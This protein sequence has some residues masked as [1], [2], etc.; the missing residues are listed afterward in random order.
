[1]SERKA[2]HHQPRQTPPNPIQTQPYLH[3]LRQPALATHLALAHNEAQRPLR[4]LHAFE[5]VRAVLV[6][7]PRLCPDRRRKVEAVAA[8]VKVLAH[9]AFVPVAWRA[10]GR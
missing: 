3:A 9:L 10:Q 5:R 2:T 7:R 1:M 8:Q 4:P 6:Q